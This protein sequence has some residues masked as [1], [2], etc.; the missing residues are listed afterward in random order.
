MTW[1][2]NVEESFMT[3]FQKF[4]LYL[5]TSEKQNPQNPTP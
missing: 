5:M 1:T 3:V 4:E 2:G